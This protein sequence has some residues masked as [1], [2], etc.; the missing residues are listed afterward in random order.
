VEFNKGGGFIAQQTKRYL[1][2]YVL[3]ESS[4]IFEFRQVTC[5]LLDEGGVSPK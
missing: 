4:G 3:Y 2:L 1:N 5:P